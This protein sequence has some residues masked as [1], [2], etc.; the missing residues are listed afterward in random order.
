MTSHLISLVTKKEDNDIMTFEKHVLAWDWCTKVVSS[1]PLMRSKR[2]RL[3]IFG[4]YNAMYVLSLNNSFH[5]YF[6]L[7][8]DKLKQKQNL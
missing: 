8:T 4:G 7:E 1:N 6:T 3:D 2:S 5:A